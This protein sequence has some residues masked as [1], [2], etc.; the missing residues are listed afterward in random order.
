MFYYLINFFYFTNINLLQTF[1]LFNKPEDKEN[2]QE[3]WIYLQ[4]I[5]Q[6]IFVSCLI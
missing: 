4:P 3:L 6:E 5:D 1:E 2:G